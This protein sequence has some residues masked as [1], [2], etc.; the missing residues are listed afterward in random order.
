[1]NGE[2]HTYANQNDFAGALQALTE[3]KERGDKLR[4][5]ATPELLAVMPVQW[6]MDQQAE[7]SNLFLTWEGAVERVFNVLGTRVLQRVAEITDDP[8]LTRRT[9]LSLVLAHHA[10]YARTCPHC[11]QTMVVVK[12]ITPEEFARQEHTALTWDNLRP[13]R[14]WCEHPLPLTGEEHQLIENARYLAAITQGQA[15]L[16][17]E[18]DETR[19]LD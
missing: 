18:G 8:Q 12:T 6:V 14:K 2:A 16:V 5:I 10:L 11:K 17:R 7:H 15:G 4:I 9:A 1:M 13:R 19:F 3:Q